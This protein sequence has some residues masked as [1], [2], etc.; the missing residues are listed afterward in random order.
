MIR[1]ILVALL[2]F[3]SP[4]F[5]ADE[6][7]ASATEV[8]PLLL[9][10]QAPDSALKTLDGKDTSLWK[11]MDGKPAILVFYRGGWCPY[12]NTQLSDLRLIIKDVEALGYQV[13]AI[14]PDRPE[15]LA[16]TMSKD[17]LDY[18]L[19]SDSKAAA[20]KAFGIAFRVDDATIKKYDGYGIDLEK[21]SGETHHALPVPSVFIVDSSHI[22][23]FSFTHP[24][25]RVRVPGSVILAAAKSIAKQE[26][27]VKPKR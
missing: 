8:H 6:I 19:L 9:G 5:A 26:Q 25:Y 27:I 7:A 3:S 21:A 13:I 23:Q 11:Q 14:S 24:D 18:T 12:C 1:T 10:S 22:L 2:L 15:E 4:L 20:I 17:E 16:K